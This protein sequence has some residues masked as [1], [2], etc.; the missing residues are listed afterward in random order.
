VTQLEKLYG[1]DR[2]DYFRTGVDLYDNVTG[3]FVELTTPKGLSGHVA[4][5]GQQIWHPING[6]VMEIIEFVPY[7]LK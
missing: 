2:F 5:Y 4:Q 3:T 6:E 7:V 1:K